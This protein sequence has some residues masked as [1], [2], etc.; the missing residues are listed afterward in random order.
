ME[1]DKTTLS[2]FKLRWGLLASGFIAGQFARGLAQSRTGIAVA[3]GS[4]CQESADRFASEFPSIEHRHASYEALLENPEV[5]AVYIST[6]HPMHHEWAIKT[7]QAGKH[8]L[9]EKP[10]GMNAREAEEIIAAARANGVFLMEAYM[11]RC[12]AQTRVVVELIR[13]GEIGEIRT[14]AAHFSFDGGSDPQCRLLNKALGGGGILDVGGYPMSFA[15]LIA[16][17]AQGKKFADPVQLHAIGHLGET[18]VDDYTS[19]IAEFPGNIHARLSVGI[20]VEE[21]TRVTAYG[22]KGRIVINE[23]WKPAVDGGSSTVEIW[24]NTAEPTVAEMEPIQIDTPHF[25]YAAE[26]DAVGDAIAAGNTQ[27]A[28]PAMSWDDTLGNIHAMDQWRAAIGLHYDA[29]A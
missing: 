6:P 16:G 29:D 24:R 3:I 13:S 15:R 11:Y 1:K 4:R 8:I 18:G 7:A 21:E 10:I 14:I 25:L 26:A 20:R 5:D 22:T 23:P 12:S 28:S 17:V 9:C 2:D 19:A 27:A